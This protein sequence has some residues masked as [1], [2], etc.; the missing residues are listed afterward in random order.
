MY[1]G[2]HVIEGGRN[3]RDAYLVVLGAGIFCVGVA[4]VIRGFGL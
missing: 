4:I 3:H 1:Y 2:L